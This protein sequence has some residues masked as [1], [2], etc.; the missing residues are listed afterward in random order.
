[1]E[2][3]KNLSRIILIIAI[4]ILILTLSQNVIFRLPDAYLYYFND[5]QCLSELYITMSNSE[6]ADALT[7]LIN[8]VRPD[9]DTFNIYVDTGYDKLGI[10][11]SRDSY[12][13]LVLKCALDMGFLLGILSLAALII[14]YAFLLRNQ[15]KKM[16]RVSFKIGAAIAGVLIVLQAALFSMTSLREWF[17]TVLGVRPFH[18]D[19]VL[20]VMLSSGFWNMAT[21][22]LT[23]AAVVALGV[24]VYVQHRLTQPPRMFY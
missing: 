20:N 16:L 1:M 18:E 15:E 11:E 5:S 22:F 4:P 21:V 17:F 13:L 8:T 7:D 6:V 12:N 10:F 24:A 3:L 19:S 14:V 2:R 9:T 23:I